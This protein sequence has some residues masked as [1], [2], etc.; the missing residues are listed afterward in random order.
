MEH[1]LLGYIIQS[2]TLSNDMKDVI[3]GLIKY[4]SRVLFILKSLLIIHLFSMVLILIYHHET[5]NIASPFAYI[6]FILNVG[7]NLLLLNSIRRREKQVKL[8]SDL[9]SKWLLF[10]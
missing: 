5:F 7:L 6:A 2:E 8:L 9:L 1:E 3:V 10:K 4:K